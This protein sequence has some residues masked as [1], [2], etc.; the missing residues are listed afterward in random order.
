LNAFPRAKNAELSVFVGLSNSPERMLGHNVLVCTKSLPEELEDFAVRNIQSLDGSLNWPKHVLAN[1]ERVILL[2][3]EDFSTSVGFARWGRLELSDRFPVSLERAPQCDQE[4]RA[5]ILQHDLISGTKTAED[6]FAALSPL[7][8]VRKI[9]TTVDDPKAAQAILNADI[10][11][12]VGF[13]NLGNSNAITPF[14]SLAAGYYTSIVP[15]SSQSRA[16]LGQELLNEAGPRTYVEIDDTVD[17][18]VTSCSKMLRRLRAMRSQGFQVNPE[19]ARFARIN[20]GYHLACM[21]RFEE[22]LQKC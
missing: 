5:V 2:S 4:L 22:N 18:A 1:F 9:S 16:E 17:D 11:V 15:S 14:D 6:L 10:H 21:K 7:C 20:E 19:L 13:F 3:R 8:S 12:H